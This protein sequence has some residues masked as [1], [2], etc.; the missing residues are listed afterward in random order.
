MNSPR[1]RPEAT[2]KRVDFLIRPD[3]D[4]KLRARTRGIFHSWLHV[5][6]QLASM[7]RRKS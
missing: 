2:P 1:K 5:F 4:G 3:R 6:R 7:F